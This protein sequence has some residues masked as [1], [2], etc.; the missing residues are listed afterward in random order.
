MLPYELTSPAEEDLKEISRY[1]LMHWGKKQSLRYARLLE[2]RFREI[3][4]RDGTLALVFKTL[5]ASQGE[6]V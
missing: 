4:A 3:A 2:K 1:T 6:P 5:S